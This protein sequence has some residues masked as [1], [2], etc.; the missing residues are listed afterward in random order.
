MMGSILLLVTGPN[1]AENIPRT[2]GAESLHCFKQ[3]LLLRDIE[4]LASPSLLRCICCRVSCF[5]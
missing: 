1:L 2:V 5:D 4:V 3:S